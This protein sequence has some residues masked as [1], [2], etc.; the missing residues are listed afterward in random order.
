MVRAKAV[1]VLVFL[2]GAELRNGHDCGC[3]DYR[4]LRFIRVEESVDGEKIL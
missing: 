1:L 3:V 2:R 4:E